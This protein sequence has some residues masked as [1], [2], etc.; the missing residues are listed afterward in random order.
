M[1]HLLKH[2]VECYFIEWWRESLTRKHHTELKNKLKKKELF[3]K[4]KDKAEIKKENII[5]SL[6]RHCNMNSC[7]NLYS[8]KISQNHKLTDWQKTV[9]DYCFEQI[10]S[11][12]QYALCK[13]L[14]I[15]KRFTGYRLQVRTAGVLISSNL[16]FFFFSKN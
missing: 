4:C 2:N 10:S 11:S 12:Y 8:I 3:H 7:D 5:N 6:Q 9:T 15:F 1:V 14:A 16:N 13:Y